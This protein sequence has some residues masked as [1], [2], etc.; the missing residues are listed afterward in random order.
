MQLAKRLARTGASTLLVDFDMRKPTLHHMIDEPR[1]PGLSEF[2]RGESELGPLVRPTGIENLSLLTAG[3]PFLNSLGALSN[4]VTRSL[5]DKVR[6]GFDFVIVDGT[7]IL[8]VVD[9]LL[10]GQH[11]DSVILSMRRDVSQLHRV[12][13]A[14]ERLSAF[15][16]EDFAAVL[17]GTSEEPYD[18]EDPEPA[19]V[20]P[21]EERPKPR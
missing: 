12:R 21:T 8:P 10:I 5:F 14:C 9:A 4:G 20:S 19:P 2:L 17:T 1:G 6:D 16:V 11:V 3:S 13:A 15:G 7:P 18:Y